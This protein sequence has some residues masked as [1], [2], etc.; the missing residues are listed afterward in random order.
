[1][2][3]QLGYT[4]TKFKKHL[5]TIAIEIGE[6]SLIFVEKQYFQ[7]LIFYLCFLQN[8]IYIIKK[9]KYW[10]WIIESSKIVEL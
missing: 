9:I 10:Q 4:Y 8:N 5:K 3:K 1:M 6:Y 2:E 7:Y